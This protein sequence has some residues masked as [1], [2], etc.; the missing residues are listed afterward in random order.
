MRGRTVRTDREA[1]RR[2]RTRNVDE[3]RLD[4]A[5]V[6]TGHEHPT[7][8]IPVLDQVAADR[9]ATRRARTRHAGEL[10][11]EL[12][13][14]VRARND[15]PTRSIPLFDQCLR[16]IRPGRAERTDRET[17]R[18]ARARHRV[19]RTPVCAGRHRTRDGRPARA[20]PLL[21]EPVM[22]SA[23]PDGETTCRAR[24]RHRTDHRVGRSRRVGTRDDR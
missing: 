4:S 20:I 2:T 21:D 7:R 15:R 24:A 9:E 16:C 1:T 23:T 10:T 6:R 11:G 8:P 19:E 14:P 12:M 5:E 3:C 22:G 13:R 17:T 18:H